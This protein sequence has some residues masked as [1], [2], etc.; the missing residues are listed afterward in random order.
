LSF[1]NGG[2]GGATNTLYVT[3]GLN[4]EEDGLFAQINAVPEPATMLLMAAGLGLVLVKRR[5]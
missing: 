3:A 2:N 5:A 4:G 1:G